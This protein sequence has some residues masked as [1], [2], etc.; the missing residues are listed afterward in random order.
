MSIR[1]SNVFPAVVRV[2]TVLA[3]FAVPSF[4]ASGARDDCT[5]YTGYISM[6]GLGY[7]SVPT[8]VVMDHFTPVSN[9]FFPVN[10]TSSAGIFQFTDCG[11]PA[12]EI[13]YVVS[14]VPWQYNLGVA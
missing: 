4:G 3:A 11:E 10:D 5:D 13:V 1:L 14:N 12:L 2:T 7:L 9:S 6:D 8:P